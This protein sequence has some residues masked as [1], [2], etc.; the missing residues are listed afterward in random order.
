MVRDL[1]LIK[2]SEARWKVRFQTDN[3]VAVMVDGRGPEDEAGNVGSDFFPRIMFHYLSL[4]S[5]GR[6]FGV[7][8]RPVFR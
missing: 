3:H 5:N 6:R 4:A 7:I 2:L 8:R 1:G